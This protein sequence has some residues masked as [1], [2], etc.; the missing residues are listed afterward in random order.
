M[1]YSR[2]VDFLAFSVYVCI[3]I[4]MNVSWTKAWPF[5]FVHFCPPQPPR[6]PPA[7]GYRSTATPPSSAAV[8]VWCAVLLYTPAIYLLCYYN[9]LYYISRYVVLHWTPLVWVCV[10]PV[11]FFYIVTLHYF[12]HPLPF[13]FFIYLHFS[14]S[15]TDQLQI[16]HHT[17]A[18]PLTRSLLPATSF[19][20]LAYYIMYYDIRG[21]EPV[22]KFALWV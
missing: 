18:I 22:P 1:I 21:L 2:F 3:I 5:L 7:H 12:Y 6:I 8:A 9:I 20:L 4:R 11:F 19:M 17:A 16:I 14:Y 13:S 15:S 10:F